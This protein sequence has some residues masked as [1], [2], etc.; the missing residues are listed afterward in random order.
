MF[1]TGILVALISSA[2]D[3]AVPIYLEANVGQAPA[4][5]LVQGRGAGET[6]R[7]RGG[8]L[9]IRTIVE[10]EEAVLRFDRGH[11]EAPRFEG[12]IAAPVREVRPQASFLIPTFVR[13]SLGEVWT[14]VGVELAVAR[15]GFELT[16]EIAPGAD[17]ARAGFLVPG[18]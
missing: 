7:V 4:D 13:A 1:S 12:A 5:V 10:S 2:P 14:G 18:K 3:G 11:A 17:P 16:L 9:G 15:G 6:L 8:S